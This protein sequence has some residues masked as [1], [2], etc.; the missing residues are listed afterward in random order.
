MSQPSTLGE[1]L[2][3]PDGT[4]IL[5]SETSDWYFGLSKDGTTIQVSADYGTSMIASETSDWYSGTWAAS[6]RIKAPVIPDI[7][8]VASGIIGW[9]F[10]VSTASVQINAPEIHHISIVAS[11]IIGQCLGDC[12][13]REDSPRFI[14]DCMGGTESEW[15][16]FICN[17][18]EWKKRCKRKVP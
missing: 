17:L 12:N 11:E 3:M 15:L 2:Y 18:N 8:I 16:S 6:M 7:D 10:E 14:Y 4:S 13:I 1:A 5:S 9:C